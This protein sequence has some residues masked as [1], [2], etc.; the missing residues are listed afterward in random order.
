[1]QAP[2]P[3]A[4]PGLQP[5]H[6]ALRT[7]LTPPLRSAPHMPAAHAVLPFRACQQLLWPSSQSQEKIWE[8]EVGYPDWRA[9]CDP[10]GM[11]SGR[12]E[13]GGIMGCGLRNLIRAVSCEGWAF[14]CLDRCL[15]RAQRTVSAY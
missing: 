8:V 3:P 10:A 15:P 9:F 13:V 12:D 4:L 14:V 7:G 1:M 5:L 11:V 2:A 6:L